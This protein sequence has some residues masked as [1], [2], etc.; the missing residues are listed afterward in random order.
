MNAL[1]QQQIRDKCAYD[2]GVN[3]LLQFPGMTQEILESFFIPD[4]QPNAL[5]L[6]EIYE[7]MLL[8]ATNVGHN[9]NTVRKHIGHIW[10][11]QDATAQVGWNLMRET[12]FHFDAKR[13]SQT[14]GENTEQWAAVW[15]AIKPDGEQPPRTIERFCKTIISA[16]SFIN[17][18]NSA[19]DFYEWV[20][21]FD[22]DS[23]ARAAL[24]MLIESEVYGYGFALACDFIKGLGYP[25]FPKPDLHLM[26]ICRGLGLCSEKA[27]S[28]EVYKTT[29]RAAQNAGVTPYAYDRVFYIIGSENFFN[30]TVERP[31]GI[32]NTKAI[33]IQRTRP[34]L[35]AIK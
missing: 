27:T 14:F 8:S 33:F 35:D 18:F 5:S 15:G 34:I 19:D 22:R 31:I 3:F 20:N 29:I 10:F 28:F 11:D 7:R 12:L 2:E 6:N 26:D 32:T 4:S 1:E 16:A 23:R 25:N 17:Q 21:F 30:Q 13:I 9:I 24:P